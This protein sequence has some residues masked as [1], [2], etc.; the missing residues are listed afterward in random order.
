VSIALG[1]ATK[2]VE[3][4]PLSEYIEQADQKMYQDKQ[5][6][7]RARSAAEKRD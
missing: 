6:D 3:G 2:L 5:N 1:I 7:R 4:K